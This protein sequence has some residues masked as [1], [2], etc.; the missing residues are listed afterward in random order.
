MG[1]CF[2]KPSSKGHKKKLKDTSLAEEGEA[3]ELEKKPWKASE[4]DVEGAPSVSVVAPS[5]AAPS[6]LP[7]SQENR[8]L[9][10]A[11]LPAPA[12]LPGTAA[13]TES[14]KPQPP[15]VSP[16]VPKP[17]PSMSP[18]PAPVAL[19]GQTPMKKHS[20]ELT[21]RKPSSPCK[22]LLHNMPS[23]PGLKKSS[24]RNEEDDCKF[25]S[26][27]RKQWLSQ[28][29]VSE[30]INSANKGP[31]GDDSLTVGSKAGVGENMPKEKN[32]LDAEALTLTSRET[33]TL[34]S[35]DCGAEALGRTNKGCDAKT[36]ANVSKMSAAEAPTAVAG[37]AV[38]SRS[39]SL[40]RDMSPVEP[41]RAKARP[42]SPLKR[43][44]S[45]KDHAGAAD[46]PRLTRTSSGKVSSPNRAGLHA[47][48]RHESMK[49]RPL[50]K[51]SLSKEFLMDPSADPCAH[52]RSSSR[53]SVSEFSAEIIRK[54]SPPKKTPVVVASSTSLSSLDANRLV[55]KRPS[56]PSKENVTTNKPINQEPSSMARGGRT[57]AQRSL[58]AAVHE[59]DNPTAGNNNRNGR[60]KEK[61]PLRRTCNGMASLHSSTRI[62][63]R[64]A[65]LSINSDTTAVDLLG[66]DMAARTRKSGTRIPLKEISDNSI[67]VTLSKQGAKE[68]NGPPIKAR[69]ELPVQ[70]GSVAHELNLK[71]ETAPGHESLGKMDEK[72]ML[73]LASNLNDYVK[74][75]LEVKA[76]N[77]VMG[78]K[79]VLSA[80]KA[81]EEYRLKYSNL[82]LESRKGT[83]ETAWYSR[84]QPHDTDKENFSQ[85]LQGSEME[86]ARP[87]ANPLQAQDLPRSRSTKKS[88]EQFFFPDVQSLLMSE[89]EGMQLEGGLTMPASISKACSILRA[90]ADLNMGTPMYPKKKETQDEIER[91]NL[92]SFQFGEGDSHRVTLS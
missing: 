87:K 9:S 25:P 53:D 56:T 22:S 79:S 81:L 86:K 5:A 89:N 35:K 11:P 90:V 27:A 70:K 19:V 91:P 67:K 65:D 48:E 20:G 51:Q 78:G 80:F 23:S 88:C 82:N 66:K 62:G 30:I 16:T 45:I 1:S 41:A 74:D 18:D 83:E 42:S 52:K 73:D 37:K 77:L 40:S 2:S 38:S 17:S 13:F 7:L 14:C 43:S 34:A 12:A 26:L 50:H 49:A 92:L 4:G 63:D 55:A 39:N 21:L 64:N 61:S 58:S 59:P 85:P 24:Y 44:P 71:G 10:P 75:P 32:A 69:D 72:A 3:P 84:Q 47:A 33:L 76:E 60:R 54:P 8:Q 31:G 46:G 68:T 28:A 15:L 29:C 6:S 36:M 57:P